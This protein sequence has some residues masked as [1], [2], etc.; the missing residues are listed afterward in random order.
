MTI[1]DLP[2]AHVLPYLE[3]LGGASCID[4][5]LALK[6]SL[7]ALEQMEFSNHTTSKRGWQGNTIPMA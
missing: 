4:T 3:D 7:Q 5:L 2:K 1:I 6:F